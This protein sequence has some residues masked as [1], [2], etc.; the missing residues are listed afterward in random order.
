M[1]TETDCLLIMGTRGC[2]KSYLCQ[3]IQKIFPRRVIIDS[4]DEYP[5]ENAVFSFDQFAQ[6]IVELE[7][8]GA[9]DFEIVFKFDP[10]VGQNT[11]EFDELLRCL[12][13]FGNIQIVIEEV[14]LFSAPHS[15][16]KWLKNCLLT[17]RHQ[18]LSLIF[19]T[20]RPGE[21]NKTILSQCNHI[22]CGRLVEGNDLRYVSAFL[23]QDAAK[24]S[25]LQDRNFLYFSKNGV[26]EF[27][28]NGK[29]S[30]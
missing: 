7:K 23:N 15:V 27:S 18:G 22:F 8:T 12:Y 2:G 20:Q 29:K 16:P 24:L 11:E 28:T 5:D 13:Y 25:T 17:G 21:L 4:V 3:M 19:T 10:E 6:K 1:I 26:S 9:R 30:M 14:Q